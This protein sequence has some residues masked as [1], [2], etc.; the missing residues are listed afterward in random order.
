MITASLSLIVPACIVLALGCWVGV[1]LGWLRRL[2]Q[3][4]TTRL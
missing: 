4:L 1:L 3:W 2:N